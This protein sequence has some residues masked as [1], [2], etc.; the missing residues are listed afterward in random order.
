[1]KNP[2]EGKLFNIISQSFKPLDDCNYFVHLDLAQNK[3]NA[4][5]AMSRWLSTNKIRVELIMR[6]DPKM[7]GGEINFE[8]IR[9]YIF[10]LKDM[11]FNI[12]KLTADGFQ[13]VDFLQIIKRRGI[14]CDVLSLDRTDVPYETFKSKLLE[15]IVELPWVDIGNTRVFESPQSPEEWFLKEAKTLEKAGNKITKPA[16]GTKDVIDAVTGCVYDAVDI[17]NKRAR[18]LTAKII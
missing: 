8:D 17:G 13:S 14:D 7:L 2:V 5:L 4:A 1:V 6:F 3:C 11:G 15:G 16:K 9:E 10:L 12:R 18:K